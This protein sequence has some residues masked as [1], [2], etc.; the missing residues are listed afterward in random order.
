MLARMRL[1]RRPLGRHVDRPMQRLSSGL[2]L[3]AFSSWSYHIAKSLGAPKRSE[4]LQTPNA[5]SIRDTIFVEPRVTRIGDTVFVETKPKPEP[6]SEHDEQFFF[7]WPFCAHDGYYCTDESEARSEFASHIK[8]DPS[9]RLKLL[10]FT[11]VRRFRLFGYCFGPVI[12]I[13]EPSEV[14]AV[15]GAPPT[16]APHPLAPFLKSGSTLAC[17]AD[18]IPAKEQSQTPSPPTVADLARAA[19]SAK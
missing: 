16:V 8:D 7:I 2:G 13:T 12:G 9:G 14:V 6:E 1:L 11:A 18:G 5:T 17:E 19:P 15:H 10:R 3:A 4:R